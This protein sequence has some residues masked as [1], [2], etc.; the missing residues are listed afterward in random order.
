THAEAQ[1]A[2]QRLGSSLEAM[3]QDHACSLTRLDRARTG[4][5]SGRAAAS[6][7]SSP[8]VRPPCP[9]DDFVR[10]FDDESVAAAGGFRDDLALVAARE[11][12]ECALYGSIVRKMWTDGSSATRAVAW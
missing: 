7:Y 2:P 11:F 1:T 10:V 4:L 5:A 6:R 12:G 8:S 3:N 9:Y